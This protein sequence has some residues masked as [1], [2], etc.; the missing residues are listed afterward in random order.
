[1][2]SKSPDKIAV[3]YIEFLATHWKKSLTRKVSRDIVS[4]KPN[5][6]QA[7]FWNGYHNTWIDARL[8]YTLSHLTIYQ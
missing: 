6:S 8:L 1:M 3:V 2:R 5:L 4:F 7:F